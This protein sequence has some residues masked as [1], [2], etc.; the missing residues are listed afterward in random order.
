MT[1]QAANPTA[2]V[3]RA[4]TPV[5]SQPVE[6]LDSQTITIPSDKPDAGLALSQEEETRYEELNGVIRQH[7]QAFF[8]VGCALEVIQRERL[9]RKSY[10]SFEEYL[11][12]EHNISRA[13]GYRLIDAAQEGM[14]VSQIGDTPKLENAHQAL[15]HKAA[16][17]PRL[18]LP[19]VVPDLDITVV[20]DEDREAPEP[21]D[22]ILV[23]GEPPVSKVVNLDCPR[24]LAGFTE[25]HRNAQ[26]AYN[27]M[28]DTRRRQ[29]AQNL[30]GKLMDQLD[31]HRRW[32]E[33]QKQQAA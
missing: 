8:D 27:I 5:A 19:P 24:N 11:N 9:Y 33:A 2:V 32:D 31:A 30:V 12:K 3:R 14:K 20:A 10:R 13:H 21:T 28:S 25:M 22:A 16:Q 23:D 18:T 15:K 6:D 7:K 29:E 26:T 1:N 4:P 17:R